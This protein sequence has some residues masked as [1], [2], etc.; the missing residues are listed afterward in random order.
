ML[1]FLAKF[2]TNIIFSQPRA[3]KSQ[4]KNAEMLINTEFFGKSQ[5][6]IPIPDSN[7]CFSAVF[8]TKILRKS[9]IPL[10]NSDLFQP[11]PIWTPKLKFY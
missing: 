11:P 5:L 1:L 7:F 2:Y 8:S 6:K 10:F 4:K 9:A 3:R